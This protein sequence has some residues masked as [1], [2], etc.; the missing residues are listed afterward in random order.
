MSGSESEIKFLAD[1][2][3]AHHWPHDTPKWDELTNRDID[4]YLNKNREKMQITLKSNAI[5]IDNYKFTEIKKVGLTIPLFKNESI[6]VFEGRFENF[7]AHVH[8]TTK[9]KEYL[10]IFNKLFYWRSRYFPDSV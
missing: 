1:K 3:H 7:Y 4:Q 9:A 2:V 10:E 6:L 8:I 5:L